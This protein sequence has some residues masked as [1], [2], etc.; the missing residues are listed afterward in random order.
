M[1]RTYMYQN[2]IRIPTPG[3]ASLPSMPSYPR[4]SQNLPKQTLRSL[5]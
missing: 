4:H 2:P 5:E 1:C 3:H